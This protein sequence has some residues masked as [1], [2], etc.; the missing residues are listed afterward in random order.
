VPSM[1]TNTVSIKELRAL[2]YFK[3]R[4]TPELATFTHSAAHF[5][6]NI[7]PQLYRSNTTIRNAVIAVS[8]LHELTRSRSMGPNKSATNALYHKSYSNAVQDLTRRDAPPSQHIVLMSCLIFLAC[9]N[10]LESAP[11]VLIHLKAG[12]QVLR[13]QRELNPPSPLSTADS[14]PDI[15]LNYLE[16]IFARLEA[17]SSLIPTLPKLAD[18]AA[19]DLNWRAPTLPSLFEDMNTARNCMHDVIQYTWFQGKRNKGAIFPDN[20]TYHFFLSQLDLWDDVFTTSFPL[21]DEP[22]WPFY[23]TATA[24]R[25]HV[26]TLALAFR[27]EASSDPLWID[28]QHAEVTQMVSDA[29]AIILAGLPDLS[30]T[31]Y[32]FDDIWHHDFCLQPPL[33][34][35]GLHVRDPFLRRKVLHLKRLHHC[36]YSPNEPYL[37]CG[38]ARM[39]ELVIDIEQRGPHSQPQTRYTSTTGSSPDS[40]TYIPSPPSSAHSPPSQTTSPPPQTPPLHH[41]IRPLTVIL[42]LP[43][44]LALSYLRY[45]FSNPDKD[46]YFES[47]SFPYWRP[48]PINRVTLWPFTEMI[49]HGN[50][51][52]MIRPQ[53]GHCLCGS[54][55]GPQERMWGVEAS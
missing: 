31:T 44:Q 34:L 6:E 23:L 5:W 48:P 28:T 27:H 15:L 35:L 37:A 19:Y 20:P 18:F 40:N 11:G 8:S 38:S 2:Q 36:W 53:R 54:L 30:T 22:T 10:L 50:F 41:R 47:A 46:T 26:K 32:G 14:T 1:W 4:A 55:G 43:Q 9:A 29:E 25:L 17:Q 12:L 42:S 13:E 52:G 16:P 51:Q 33:M 45:P 21:H 49:V 24:L 3:G 7:I 39:I